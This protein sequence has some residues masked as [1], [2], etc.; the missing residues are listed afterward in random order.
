[1]N[2]T[3]HLFKLQAIFTILSVVLYGFSLG[4]VILKSLLEIGYV[5][6]VGFSCSSLAFSFDV[7]YTVRSHF[8]SRLFSESYAL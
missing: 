8:S 7:V 5:V 4:T 1:M 6:T 3:C 2:F